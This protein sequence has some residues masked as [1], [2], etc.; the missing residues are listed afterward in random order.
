MCMRW[1]WDIITWPLRM[2]TGLIGW[3]LSAVGNLIAFFIGLG[4]CSLGVLISL[5]V[6]GAIIGIP[7]VIFGGG[8]MLSSIF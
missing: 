3:I 6:V 4:L 8:L 2:A 7:L 1:L 5:T